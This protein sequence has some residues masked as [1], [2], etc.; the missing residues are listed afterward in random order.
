M[1]EQHELV[2][3]GTARSGADVWQCPRCPHRMLTRWRPSFQ[4]EVLDEGD[5]GVAHT[6]NLGAPMAARQPLR[7]PA[8]P[9]TAGE[10]TWLDRLG[11]DWNTSAA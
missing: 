2:Y 11:I 4:A 6:G 9:L 8:A 7:G 5:P 3:I 10:R 1:P